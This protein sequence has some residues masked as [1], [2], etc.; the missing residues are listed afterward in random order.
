MKSFAAALL[1]SF[2][3]AETIIASGVSVDSGDVA[4]NAVFIAMPGTVS[5]SIYS[6]PTEGS[7][8]AADTLNAWFFDQAKDLPKVCTSGQECR[9][10]IDREVTQTVEQQWRDVIVQIENIWGNTFTR[11]Q[12][13]L[14]DAY[15]AARA[16]EPGC[17]CS[18]ITVEYE[19]LVRR[20]TTITEE[21]YTLTTIER[22]LH[23]T[24]NGYLISCPEYEDI[25]LSGDEILHVY[26]K[27]SFSEV[28][29]N[30]VG[31]EQHDDELLNAD[32][33]RTEDE[34]LMTGF[35]EEGKTVSES[36]AKIVGSDDGN[37]ETVG[38]DQF[39]EKSYLTVQDEIPVV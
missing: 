22:E 16:C 19:D 32:Q 20:Q 15:E 1:A 11:S 6:D 2:A 26:D 29:V 33:T 21:V 8:A 13:I 25:V 7:I 34:F 14:E 23:T 28:T 30:E 24:Q 10:S 18:E 35:E 39:E 4:L 36:E 31:R 9:V 3:T 38:S 5:S 17:Y 27:S 37:W 12:S